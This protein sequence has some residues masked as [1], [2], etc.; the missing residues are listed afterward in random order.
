MHLQTLAVGLKGTPGSAQ[1]CGLMEEICHAPVS[2]WILRCA[3]GRKAV[4]SSHGHCAARYHDTMS[5]YYHL[6]F[7]GRNMRRKN[8]NA[9]LVL[10]DFK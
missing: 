7:V 10:P 9:F 2:V 6:A 4:W 1:P 8:V 3:E 5:S